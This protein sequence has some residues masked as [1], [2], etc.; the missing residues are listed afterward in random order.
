MSVGPLRFQVVADE[1]REHGGQLLATLN[2]ECIPSILDEFTLFLD[3]VGGAGATDEVIEILYPDEDEVAGAQL[4][5]Y[6]ELRERLSDFTIGGLV[7][8]PVALLILREGLETL[9]DEEDVAVIE[10]PATEEPWNSDDGDE[11]S[12]QAPDQTLYSS[13]QL[14]DVSSD[15]GNVE[16]LATG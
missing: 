2:L 3:D 6:Q 12:G 16:G 8:L 1:V 11:T 4:T 5:K 14:G 9:G 10:E 15:G 13:E 7:P